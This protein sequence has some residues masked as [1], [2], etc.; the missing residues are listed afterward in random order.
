MLINKYELSLMQ[1]VNIENLQRLIDGVYSD[2]L[3]HN[4]EQF[5]CNTACCIA[6]WDVALHFGLT[7]SERLLAQS[8]D[9]TLSSSEANDAF[10]EPWAFSANNNNLTELEAVLIF[11]YFVTKDLHYAMLDF[12]KQ[13]GRLA[14]ITGKYD[15]S[16]V[17]KD[18]RRLLIILFDEPNKPKFELLANC[19]E[20]RNIYLQLS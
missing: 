1:N 14:N 3:E 7:E 10:D 12:F 16:L 20:A 5:F 17:Q 19:L 8:E 18:N 2:E 11:D 13:G 15:V 9:D 6:G 4:Q